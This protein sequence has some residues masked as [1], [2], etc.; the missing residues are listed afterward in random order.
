MGAN[1][2]GRCFSELSM[3]L[4]DAT[5]YHTCQTQNRITAHCLQEVHQITMY[6]T[7]E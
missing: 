1:P 4:A 3:L 7:P 2:F 5:Q 6:L